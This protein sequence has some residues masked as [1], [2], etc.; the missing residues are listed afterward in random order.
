MIRIQKKFLKGAEFSLFDQDNNLVAKNLVT[1]EDGVL[2][3]EK[4]KEGHYY[5]VETKAPTDYKKTA[6]KYVFE[7]KKQETTQVEQVHVTNEKLPV[8]PK[9]PTEPKKPV[10]PTTTDKFLPKTGEIKTNM[11]LIGWT[12]VMSIF[13]I[14][15][16]KYHDTHQL[17]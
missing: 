13:F 3:V 9:E 5:F 4:L 6:K 2:L 11:V 1:N 10:T 14:Y 17:D 12:L 15:W 16:K 7:I 8:V